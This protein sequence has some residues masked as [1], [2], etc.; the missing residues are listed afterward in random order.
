MKIKAKI[1]PEYLDE[2][3]SGK[4]EFEY[5]QIEYMELTD[6]Q[7][8]VRAKVSRIVDFDPVAERRIRARYPEVC[9]ESDLRI[10]GFLLRN[11]EVVEE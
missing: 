1:R 11:P 9:W 6:G 7:R 10:F 4:K 3:L 8:T 5:R 2:I